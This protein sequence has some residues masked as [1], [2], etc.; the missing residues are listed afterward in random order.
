MMMD[1]SA[2]TEEAP[3]GNDVDLTAQGGLE[4]A[5][6]M[7]DSSMAL[8]Q[9]QG[10]E[11]DG[12]GNMHLVAAELDEPAFIDRLPRC[13]RLC[14]CDC[15]CVCVCVCDCVCACASSFLCFLL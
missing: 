1:T 6:Q 14:V 12:F 15:V 8:A 10:E 3:Q 11:D 7:G 2:T 5:M 13:V 9:E 4:Q